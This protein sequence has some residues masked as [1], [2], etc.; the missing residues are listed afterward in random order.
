MWK[1]GAL[2]TTVKHYKLK[3]VN[4]KLNPSDEYHNNHKICLQW[5]RKGN[6][7]VVLDASS[8]STTALVG[9][10]SSKPSLDCIPNNVIQPFVT[11]NKAV[12]EPALR[13][14]DLLE[15][16]TSLK[17]LPLLIHKN[18]PMGDTPKDKYTF[19]IEIVRCRL[20][21]KWIVYLT[22]KGPAP[23]GTGKLLLQLFRQGSVAKTP[24]D[25]ERGDLKRKKMK[26]EGII[27]EDI[28]T[29]MTLR[30]G[31]SIRME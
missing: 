3:N 10:T 11:I 25:Y 31:S 2:L 30:S 15:S 8:D 21:R 13:M 14:V 22:G 27:E 28:Y 24:A 16:M 1:E 5:A 7:L 4:L 18:V 29:T 6:Y 26:Q 23:D 17:A 9:F 20:R 12:M 19:F